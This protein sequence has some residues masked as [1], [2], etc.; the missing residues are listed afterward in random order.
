[1]KCYRKKE[2]KRLKKSYTRRTIDQLQEVTDLHRMYQREYFMPG[3]GYPLA[4]SV[5]CFTIKQRQHTKKELHGANNKRFHLYLVE[6]YLFYGSKSDSVC[7]SVLPVTS[8]ESVTNIALRL[9]TDD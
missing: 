2:S 5:V 7:S 9:I 6:R 1:M 3:N 4:V 8:I